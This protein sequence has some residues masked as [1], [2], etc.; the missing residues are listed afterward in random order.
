MNHVYTITKGTL[1]GEEKKCELPFALVFEQNGVYFLETFLKDDFF[2]EGDFSKWY[3]LEG[4][5][6][7]NYLIEIRD[8]TFT[9][10]QHQ[11]K[12]AKF[13]CRNYVKLTEQRTKLPEGYSKEEQSIFFLELDGFKTSFADYTQVKKLRPYGEVD[14]FR[15]GDFDHTSCAMCIQMEGYKQ[16]YFHLI[17]SKS[18]GVGNIQIDF[19]KNGGYGRLTYSHY[20]EFRSQFIGFLSLLNGGQVKIK[21]EL[22]GEFYNTNGSDAH[23]VYYYSFTKTENSNLSSYTPIN[24]H[25][26]SSS[27]IFQNTFFKCFNLYY[28][29]DLNLELTSIVSSLNTAHSTSGIHQTYSILINALEKLS[30]NYQKSVGNFEEHV[31]DNNAWEN[32]IKPSLFKMLDEQKSTINS[33]NKNAFLAFKSQ[34][35]DLNRRKNSTSQKMYDLLEFG[36]IP[37][38]SKVENLVKNERHSA[39]H[40]GVFGENSTEMFINYQKLD[41]ILRDIILNII[42]YRSLRRSVYDYASLEERQK[43][44]PKKENKMPTLY[45]SEPLTR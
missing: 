7:K 5:T 14:E 8:L 39:V 9:R 24:D 28:H 17:F 31:M 4:I 25:H 29:N 26:S 2:K 30:S 6:E 34:I 32:I 18:N 42:D 1:I 22:T 40:D 41:H 37:I 11:N 3:N 21:K 12:K 45:C 23:I 33:T 10:Y 13:V 36:G 27:Q 19:T 43:A 35:G 16:N 38:N 44:Y 15:V 20:L